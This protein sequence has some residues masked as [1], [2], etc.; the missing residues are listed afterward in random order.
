MRTH[1]PHACRFLWSA[2]VLAALMLGT[3]L[4]SAQIAIPATPKGFT[5]RV[6]DAGGGINIS[7]GIT[8]PPPQPRLVRTTTY[9]TLSE[10]RQW[11]SADGKPVLGRLI[12]F[13]DIVVETRGNEAV[14]APQM[15]ATP[16]VVKDGR[17][18]LLV[19]TKPFELALER[20]SQAD[21]D[22]IENIRGAVARKA[23]VAEKKP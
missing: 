5:K 6:G 13:E 15:P 10:N 12:A 20:L 22:F 17:A 9:V 3:G 11:T 7:P 4:T 1:F 8:P 14:P 18:R 2:I 19:N 21:R 23:T 16:T